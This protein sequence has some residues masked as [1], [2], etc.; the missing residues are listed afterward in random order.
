MKD[1][2][3]AWDPQLGSVAHSRMQQLGRVFHQGRDAV[4]MYS[5]RL[6]ESCAERCRRFLRP[7]A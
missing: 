6:E 4:S 1:K 7:L 2:R 3:L 5:L